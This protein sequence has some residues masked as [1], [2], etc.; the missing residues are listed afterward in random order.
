L[1]FVPALFPLEFLIDRKQWIAEAEGVKEDEQLLSA[2]Y[3]G[4]KIT[5]AIEYAYG[6]FPVLVTLP[7]GL[8][9]AAHKIRG[10]LPEALLSSWILIISAPF[11][12]VIFL[13]ALILLIQ[14]SGN[15]FLLIG[16]LLLFC[17]PW[18][19]VFRRR[20]YIHAP[21]EET[22]QKLGRTQMAI[23]LIIKLGYVFL[24][25]WVFTGQLPWPKINE[26]TGE[27]E[28]ENQN[29]SEVF[30]TAGRLFN[31]ILSFFGR[32]LATTLVF[33]DVLFRM[34]VTNWRQ[35]KSRRAE[36]NGEHIDTLFQSIE[37]SI[38]RAGASKDDEEYGEEEKASARVNDSFVDVEL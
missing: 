13:M 5:L 10:L 24:L 34:T 14:V 2:L 23:G 35:D 3:D 37:S 20:L 11:Y 32:K 21:T 22:E 29:V 31:F 36:D 16:A 27:T 26:E 30:V 7:S 38:R 1:A 33:S 25:I 18:I 28:D 4:I 17:A 6:L 9:N 12:S 19:Y 8:V 15:K